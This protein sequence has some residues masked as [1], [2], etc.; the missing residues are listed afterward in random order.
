[1]FLFFVHFLH[2]FTFYLFYFFFLKYFFFYIYCFLLLFFFVSFLLGQQFLTTLHTLLR[3]E[4]A[5]VHICSSVAFRSYCRSFFSSSCV[6]YLSLSLNCGKYD[7]N[8]C[9]THAYLESKYQHIL[10]ITKSQF[11]TYSFILYK[12]YD[13]YYQQ[14][15]CFVFFC[16]LV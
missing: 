10:Q 3:Y 13:T 2:C 8:F 11:Y 9:V 5:S 6:L 1:M 14:F 15:V 12:T 4:H 16:F 7:S